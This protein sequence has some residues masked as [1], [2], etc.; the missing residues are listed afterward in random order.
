[1]RIPKHLVKKR[2]LLIL[3]GGLCIF[4]IFI[5]RLIYVQIFNNDWLTQKALEEW[6]KNIPYEA[7]RGDILDARGKVLATNISSPSVLVVPKQIKKRQREK[8]ADAL[9][10]ILGMSRRRALEKISQNELIVRLTPEG[11]KISNEKASKIKSLALPGVFIAED[12]KRDYPKGNYLAHVLGFA[13]IDNQGLTGL[14]AYYN[15]GLKGKNGSVTYFSDVRGNRMSDLKDKY[16]PPESGSSLMLTID[17]RVQSIIERELNNAV[18]LYRPD[19]ALAIAMN[20]KNG[21]ILGMS[22][23][24]DFNPA[25]YKEVPPEIYNHNLPIWRTYE[26]GSTFKVITLAASL[27]ENVVDLKKDHFYDSGSID[28]AGTHLH[29][30]KR[31]GHGS[32][33][34][35]EVVQNSCNPGFVALGER[36]GKERLFSYIEKFGFGKKTG[37]DLQGEATGILFKKDRVGP[38]ETA[39]TAFGQGVSVTPIQQ[40]TAVS[41]AING[42]YLYEPR[43]AKAW[44]DTDTGKVINRI[45]PTIKRQVIS[46]ETSKKVRETLESVVAQ[47]TGRNAYVE[48]YRV[49]GK[50]GT[51]QKVNPKGGG[52]MQG[53]YIVS[54]LGFAPANDP[55]IVVYVA[56]DHPKDTVQFGGTVSAPVAGRIIGDSLSALGVK[57]QKGGLE[58]ETRW[59]DQPMIKVP[60]LVGQKKQ[61]LQNA[62]FDLKIK[63]QGSG[64]RVTMQS[65]EAGIKVK[66]GS[67]IMIYL[68]DKKKPDD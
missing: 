48:G 65:P 15:D 29:C 61:D 66:Q 50:T 41:A 58:K 68:G 28:V 52:Y 32:E 7:E 59:P 39:T 17:S 55:E 37:I 64:D 47:G 5:V 11:R 27:Q 19:S 16:T 35:L 23:K 44:V 10:E 33:T 51:A 63:T 56:I 26:P 14:E 54:F 34:F 9:S 67:T 30:W 6:G 13:G 2:L 12:F 24:P 18:A 4:A 40:I 49:G 43:L 60:D 53:N 62:L 8:T 31:G 45:E 3:A 38:L 22:S 46:S 21:N 25:R 20:P 42:G 1:M 57:R 36:L